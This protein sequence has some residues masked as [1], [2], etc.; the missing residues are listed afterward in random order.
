MSKNTK[1]ITDNAFIEKSFIK[2]IT[3][4]EGLKSI[5]SYAFYGCSGIFY[6]EMPETI[7]Y[8]GEYAFSYCSNLYRIIMNSVLPPELS[9]VG[10]VFTPDASYSV[11]DNLYEFSI[12]V[13]YINNPFSLNAYQNDTLW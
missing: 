3:L 1:I 10:E 4:N 13:P 2:N 6:I 8:I 7:E 9:S 12:I 5:N 11:N